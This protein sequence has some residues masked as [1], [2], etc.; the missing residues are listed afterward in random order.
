MRTQRQPEEP[1]TYP[2]FAE[3][4]R[5]CESCG[6]WF[7]EPFA[8]LGARERLCP[9]CEYDMRQEARSPR[10]RGHILAL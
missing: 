9:S 5:R 1:Q 6:E 8:L 7:E 3:Q 10:R 4:M 2:A